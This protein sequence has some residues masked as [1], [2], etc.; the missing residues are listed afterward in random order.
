M[1]L[2]SVPYLRC[3]TLQILAVTVIA[4]GNQGLPAQQV[5]AS[6]AVTA[7]YTPTLMFD[8]ASVRESKPDYDAGF[9][10]SFVNPAQS[11]LFHFTNVYGWQLVTA[12]YGIEDFQLSGQPDWLKSTLYEVNAR[13]DEAADEKLAKLTVAQG[14]LEKQHMLQ[15]LLADRFRLKAHWETQE[16]PTLALVVAKGAPKLREAKDTPPTADEIKQFGDH[17]VPALYQRGNGSP[18]YEFVA[19][20]AGIDSIVTILSMNLHKTVLDRTALTGK[21]DFVL[22]YGFRRKG[23]ES[24]GTEEWPPLQE[25]IQ[26]QLGLKVEP[27]KGPVQVLVID[28]IER[29]SEN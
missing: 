25:A 13:S 27:T 23:N 17:P 19:H 6:G 22:R 12:A 4:I 3:R 10:V 11:S 15:E 18:G 26:D 2:T 28:H 21:Y 5:Q 16:L 8:V 9:T 24:D 14:S 1:M 7:A 29:P 20:G